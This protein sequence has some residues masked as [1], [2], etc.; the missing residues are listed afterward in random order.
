MILS[1]K[2]IKLKGLSCK[3][4]YVVVWAKRK[5]CPASLY[6]LTLVFPFQRGTKRIFKSVESFVKLTSPFL[7]SSRK[8]QTRVML[9]FFISSLEKIHLR[10]KP[11]RWQPSA[12]QAITRLAFGLWLMPFHPVRMKNQSSFLVFLLFCSVVFPFCCFHLD[13]SGNS[14]PS[15]IKC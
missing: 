2:P 15:D 11:R 12:T 1:G 14:V 4:N 5:V 13:S 8:R 6:T 10:P 7:P 3:W 9:S